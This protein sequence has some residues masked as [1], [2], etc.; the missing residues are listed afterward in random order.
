MTRTTI[1]IFKADVGSVA[2]HSTP[3]KKMLYLCKNVLKEGIKY[4]IIK[5]FYVTRV[6]DD[7]QLIMTHD[8]GENNKYVHKL[9]LDAF[10]EAANF[11]K[12][13]H[14]YAAGQD[15]LSD[16]FSGTLKGMGPGF[17]EMEF[18]ERKSEPIIFLMADKTEVSSFSLPFARAFMDP[19]STTGLVIDPRMQSGF[20]FEIHDI[21]EH[22]GIIL[23][24]PEE[25]YEILTL[26]SDTTK[27]VIKRIFSKDENIGIAAS[28]ST[29]KLNISAGRYVGKDDP[30]AIVRAQ[31]GL[32]AV[33]EIL[34]PFAFPQLVAGWM[35]GSH[36]G[37]WYPCSIEDSTPTYFDGPPR[38]CAIGF[39]IC[40]GRLIG[41]E[42]PEENEE[43]Y[44]E[45]KPVD[46]FEGSVWDIV[47][48][49]AMK[50]SRYMRGHGPFMPGTLPEEEM[51][52]TTKPDVLKK[53]E[54]RM[55]PL[56]E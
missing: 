8:K 51:E 36:Y 12:K 23:S 19:F 9:A 25:S 52:Y 49:E 45:H 46:Y 35:R 44:G 40:E 55:K 24:S 6:G 26:I 53:I 31:S 39:Q 38:I 20:K 14:L 10:L 33:G 43:N 18:E 28:L 11:A 7:I 21:K 42:D 48:R 47:R 56:S 16:A 50:I 34:Q 5:D 17:A 4:K 3:H 13:H 54:Q 27:Y 30:V 15:L 2:G 32:P 29:E 41:L 1:S 22:K 37:A